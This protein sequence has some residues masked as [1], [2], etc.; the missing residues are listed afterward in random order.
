MLTMRVAM[1]AVH[2]FGVQMT[3]GMVLMPNPHLFSNGGMPL[4]QFQESFLKQ[5]AA[6]AIKELFG[7]IESSEQ[8]FKLN[9]VLAEGLGL[10]MNSFMRVRDILTTKNNELVLALDFILLGEN[11]E[12]V[13]G[14]GYAIPGSA[15]GETA[16]HSVL[17]RNGPKDARATVMNSD[18]MPIAGKV[19]IRV[20][21]DQLNK[22]LAG[23]KSLQESL[24]FNRSEWVF[25]A[26]ERLAEAAG[27]WTVGMLDLF[28][29]STLRAAVMASLGDGKGDELSG[30]KSTL[31]S[32]IGALAGELSQ[33]ADNL[34]VLSLQA[35]Q[36]EAHGK[37]LGELLKAAGFGNDLTLSA[38]AAFGEVDGLS[39]LTDQYERLESRLEVLDKDFETAGTADELKQIKV[40]IETVKRQMES[41]GKTIGEGTKDLSSRIEMAIKI[42]SKLSD[43]LRDPSKAD[44]GVRGIT[45]ILRMY[46]G[47][48]VLPEP[49]YQRLKVGISEGM[50]HHLARMGTEQERELL[51]DG[52][53]TLLSVKKDLMSI[54]E[55]ALKGDYIDD[56]TG[57]NILGQIGGGLTWAGLVADARD[58]VAN[59]QKVW[60]SGGKENKGML[61][62]STIALVP[63]VGDG[64]KAIAKS[65]SLRKGVGG[66]RDGADIARKALEGAPTVF[67]TGEEALAA[68]KA[69]GI[70]V[71]GAKVLIKGGVVVLAISDE[72]GLALLKDAGGMGGLAKF[73][74]TQKIGKLVVS[75]DG[76]KAKEMMKTLDGFNSLG[77][78]S[79]EQAG[80][81]ARAEVKQAKA[82]LKEANELLVA[83]K[84]KSAEIIVDAE[85]SLA[86]SEALEQGLK[87]LKVEMDEL[88]VD[89]KKGGMS[90]DEYKGRIEEIMGGAGFERKG[91]GFVALE[92]GKVGPANAGGLEGS[93]RSV[94]KDSGGLRPDSGNRKEGHRISG[95]RDRAAGRPG[96]EV[97]P[98]VE[99]AARVR[100]RS[101]IRET[102]SEI[103][104]TA[105]G[106][107][108]SKI[109][110]VGDTNGVLR[111]ELA[112]LRAGKA[113]VISGAQEAGRG[114]R[115][116]RTKLSWRERE[117]AYVETRTRVVA[118]LEAAGAV[119]V[120]V[121]VDFGK[122]GIAL[123]E[124][125]PALR[126]EV[127]AAGVSYGNKASLDPFMAHSGVLKPA[128]GAVK[129][130]T[131]ELGE[132]AGEILI[133]SARRSLDDANNYRAVN[134]A[135]LWKNAENNR[136]YAGLYGAEDPVTGILEVGKGSTHFN[137]YRLNIKEARVLDLTNPDVAQTFNYDV[138]ASAGDKAKAYPVSQS[139][140]QKARAM[141][142]DTVKVPSVKDGKTNWVVIDNF[143]NLVKEVTTR[144]GVMAV[145]TAQQAEAVVRTARLGPTNAGMAKTVVMAM[146]GGLLVGGMADGARAA[147]GENNNGTTAAERT[148]RTMG[149]LGIGPVIDR[150]KG[151]DWETATEKTLNFGREVGA[152]GQN[153]AIG[154]WHWG[155]DM[156]GDV[157]TISQALWEAI[158]P[159]PEQKSA[160]SRLA[161]ANKQVKADL[162][163]LPI[164]NVASK[165]ERKAITAASANVQPAETLVWTPAVNPTA[166]VAP[167]SVVESDVAATVKSAAPIETKPLDTTLTAETPE[168]KGFL[169]RIKEIVSSYKE[170]ER[171]TRDGGPEEGGKLASLPASSAGL[172]VGQTQDQTIA[173]G[174]TTPPPSSQKFIPSHS[175]AG[176]PSSVKP[177]STTEALSTP[178]NTSAIEIISNNQTSILSPAPKPEGFFS[179]TWSGLKDKAQSSAAAVK[180]AVT[181]AYVSG[182]ERVTVAAQATKQKVS[183]TYDAAKTKAREGVDYALAK[184]KKAWVAVKENAVEA[185]QFT[186]EKVNGYGQNV[187]ASWSAMTKTNPIATQSVAFG[188]VASLFTGDATDKP[189]SVVFDPD[190][191]K[192][193]VVGINGVLTTVIGRTEM[194]DSIA[195]SMGVVNVAM[196]VNNTHGKGIGDFIQVFSHEY[197][198]AID[199][200]A[201]H[202]AA[203]LRQG[204]KE[205]GEVF[206][207]VHS[208]GSGI[209]RAAAKLLTPEERAKVHYLAL[210]PQVKNTKGAQG[211]A[212]AK[213]VRNAGDI[214]PALGNEWRVSSWLNP[215]EWSRKT[216]IGWSRIN[217]PQGGAVEH[218]FIEHYEDEVAIWARERGLVK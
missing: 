94:E 56:P 113:D 96:Q 187:S 159:Q 83:R 196:V 23:T 61:A 97:S 151:V 49:L 120:E 214:V 14:R 117:L 134:R 28:I 63:L 184:G 199:A 22:V 106:L 110:S 132:E 3:G 164:L 16:D 52:V 51:A 133:Y 188:M 76:P 174:V 39:T 123:G 207:V 8:N 114:A 58:I 119:R 180:T 7:G 122:E 170:D 108:D 107:L 37:I 53:D 165:V 156:V 4:K 206:A 5:A 19:N 60:A 33:T 65:R 104:E 78:A 45:D 189:G 84:A 87:K 82:A 125:L 140:V 175:A 124:V 155:G 105:S 34:K 50:S 91:D 44:V 150:L 191:K 11:G 18:H 179:R 109:Q 17:V 35:D 98:D 135:K 158:R 192:P 211:L 216:G 90:A 89:Y 47:G 205:K 38:L 118:N 77:I 10:P 139:I 85:I 129:S 166:S 186:Q 203:A 101:E 173:S 64:A 152:M 154:V 213:N 73:A 31:S 153:A 2:L 70:E 111:Q 79:L 208:Q 209:F 6:S 25:P 194:R 21:A 144:P 112:E 115:S 43:I 121:S 9:D 202:A 99:R 12:T 24:G 147:T 68:M 178:R 1:A 80:G 72:A 116:A 182:K 149:T 210:G 148:A 163:P 71:K 57:L 30:L 200:P 181:D 146:G 32:E 26:P 161:G 142:Y 145:T 69:A 20:T 100:K 48:N 162:T 126:Q 41:L 102:A 217:T 177:V 88:S 160:V 195:K 36:L 67:K 42:E 136:F 137:V 204:I 143:E 212:D 198:G 130:S 167:A 27:K 138:I 66:L 92:K 141:G 190:P 197:L 157:G 131:A 40:E 46:R 172:N 168:K 54:K 95:Q 59:S 75:V 55:G 15:F 29:P 128:K 74:E 185:A 176:P 218:G 201:V 13:V 171:V 93:W 86:R 183:D 215:L 193:A 62:M 103:R 81:A 127:K 169:A